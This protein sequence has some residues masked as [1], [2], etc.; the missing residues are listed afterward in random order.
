M[1]WNANFINDCL[2][3]FFPDGSSQIDTTH[4]ERSYYDANLGLTMEE[5]I[6]MVK[7]TIRFSKN[8]KDILKGL[9]TI[10]AQLKEPCYFAFPK[11]QEDENDFKVSFYYC[12]K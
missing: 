5:R 2:Y 8:A 3:A 4:V 10:G 9:F 1:E 12:S 6:Q 7:Y 11:V